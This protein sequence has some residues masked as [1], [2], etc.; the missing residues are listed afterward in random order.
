MV[1]SVLRWRSL[2]GR[3]GMT[4]RVLSSGRHS[5]RRAAAGALLAAS[6]LAASLLALGCGGHDKA[7][8]P[9]LDKLTANDTPVAT[10]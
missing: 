10:T 2:G 6:L 7:A 4:A 1:G 5:G 8:K 9:Q 3:I